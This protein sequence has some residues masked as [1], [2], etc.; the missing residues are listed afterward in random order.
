MKKITLLIPMLIIAFFSLPLSA[1]EDDNISEFHR[2]LIFNAKGQLMVVKI[3]NTNFWVTPGLYSKNPELTNHHL[4]QLAKE[5][6]L[7]VSKPN[8]QGVFLLKNE[9]A[10]TVSNRSFFKVNIIEGEIKKPQ[11]IDTIKWLPANE[12]KEIITFPH[13]NILLQQIIDF[14]DKVWGGSILRYKEDGEFK[15]KMI[16]D[17]YSLYEH[18]I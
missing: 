14:P 10:K 3:K 13:I 12:A 8:L 18:K 1:Q 17:F 15:A 16:K 2:L 7:T 5:Y 11:N 9:Q 6:G 4:V